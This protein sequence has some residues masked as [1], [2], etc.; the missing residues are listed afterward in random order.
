MGLE[1]R[2]LK[3]LKIAIELRRDAGALPLPALLRD[4]ALIGKSTRSAARLWLPTAVGGLV[5]TIELPL[6]L[7][8][9]TWADG[10]GVVMGLALALAIIVAVDAG[11]LA[12]TTTASANARERRRPAMSAYAMCVGLGGCVLLVPVWSGLLATPFGISEITWAAAR[13]A[14]LGLAP[15]PLLVALRRYFHGL[16]IGTKRTDWIALATVTRIMTS[17]VLATLLSV[18]FDLAA[19][20]IGIALTVAVAVEVC[21]VAFADGQARLANLRG[22][23]RDGVLQVARFH[24]PLSLSMLVAVAPVSAMLVALALTDGARETVFAWLVVFIGPLLITSATFDLEAL[25]AAERDEAAPDE[26]EDPST[27]KPPPDARAQP[28]TSAAGMLAMSLLFGAAFTGLWLALGPAAG[29]D[30]TVVWW[31]APFPLLCVT[32]EVLRGWLVARGGARPT[33]VT[34]AAG[35]L[36]LLFTLVVAYGSGMQPIAAAALAVSVGAAAEAA[37]LWACLRRLRADPAPEDGPVA[38]PDDAA[39]SAPGGPEVPTQ[40]PPPP[41]RREGGSRAG[42]SSRDDRRAGKRA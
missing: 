14:L 32:R 27:A 25:A 20:G 2:P 28:D 41:R 22:I 23:R 35:S 11:P 16:L 38:Q 24:L 5:L 7:V 36:P 29:L 1:S 34:V 37:T 8:V 31:L 17:V 33:L 39:P 19:F 26:P 6:L 12:L 30:G 4:A 3:A 18:I 15:A 40:P 10:S 9:A 21:I 13:D 42:A